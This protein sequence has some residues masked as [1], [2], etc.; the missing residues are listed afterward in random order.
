MQIIDRLI[1]FIFTICLGFLAVVMLGSTAGLIAQANFH[2]VINQFYGRA[3]VG[4]IGVIL[5]FVVIRI[6]YPLFN[7]EQSVANT[8]V[9]DNS[10]GQIRLSL[11]AIE[12]LIQKAVAQT[13]GVREVEST[14]ELSEEGLNIFLEVVVTPDINIPEISEE[15]QESVKEYLSRTTGVF[16]GR[17]E[18]LVDKIAQDSNLRVE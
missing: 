1:I 6:L 2:S 11:T 18:I 17:I 9:S 13:R 16:V 3:E 12:S 4:I 7:R 8:V 14:L 5:L 10:L 15:L